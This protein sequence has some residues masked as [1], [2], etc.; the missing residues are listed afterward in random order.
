MGKNSNAKIPTKTSLGRS[1]FKSRF[2]HAA[3][4]DVGSSDRWVVYLFNNFLDFD[5]QYFLFL[6]LKLIDKNLLKKIY[7]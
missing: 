6:L 7:S 5:L 4:N 1:L 3:S 2:S